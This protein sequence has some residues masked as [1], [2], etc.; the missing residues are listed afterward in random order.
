MDNP[1][2][3]VKVTQRYDKALFAKEDIKKEEIIAVWSPGRVY[4]ATK[5]SQLQKD[6]R[7]H[8]IQIDENKFVD[9]QGIGRYFAHS[10]EPN[11]G[12]KG[13]LII[14][15]MQDIQKGEEL[16]FDYEMCED[17]DWEMECK[18][19]CRNCRKTI[20]AFRNMPIEVR[21]KYGDYISKWLRIKY[22]L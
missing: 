5:A 11:C 20:S 2:V 18:C 14:V 12:F 17:S 19:G 15:A 22:K 8:A 21:K 10:C 9:Y 13:R 1:K 6:I 3:E 16:T 7:D 4:Q